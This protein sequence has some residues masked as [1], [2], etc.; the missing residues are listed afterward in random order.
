MSEVKKEFEQKVY[1]IRDV[2]A[3]KFFAP[4]IALNDDLAKRQFAFNFVDKSSIFAFSPQDFEL[5]RIGFYDIDN[6]M[7]Y[8]SNITKIDRGDEYAEVRV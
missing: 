6:G 4:F 3:D 8:S 2:V 7:L 1:A 5:Y